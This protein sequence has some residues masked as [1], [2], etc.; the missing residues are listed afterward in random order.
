MSSKGHTSH[1]LARIPCSGSRDGRSSVSAAYQAVQT[2]TLEGSEERVVVDGRGPPGCCGLPGEAVVAPEVCFPNAPLCVLLG[3]DVL[4][5][6][7]FFPEISLIRSEPG[8][9]HFLAVTRQASSPAHAFPAT[10]AAPTNRLAPLGASL[11]GGALPR[12]AA[13]ELL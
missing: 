12:Y 8:V 6:F 5:P 3:Q 13:G 9:R 4:L 7:P 1:D 11:G 10:E 2:E